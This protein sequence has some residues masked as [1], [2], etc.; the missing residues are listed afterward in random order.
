M[1]GG[2]TPG[3]SQRATRAKDREVSTSS[4]RSA[5][6]R[7]LSGELGPGLCCHTRGGIAYVSLSHLEAS[8]KHEAS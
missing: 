3:A 8:S 6:G 4:S 2:Q 7:P 1:S 5:R